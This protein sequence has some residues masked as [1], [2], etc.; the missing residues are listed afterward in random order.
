MLF[1]I[2]NLSFKPT[3]NSIWVIVI[4]Y[5]LYSSSEGVINNDDSICIGMTG[6]SLSLHHLM[7][8]RSVRLQCNPLHQFSSPSSFF[9]ALLSQQESFN[10]SFW[11]HLFPF[12]TIFPRG[13]QKNAPQIQHERRCAFVRYPCKIKDSHLHLNH[14]RSFHTLVPFLKF[15]HK[16]FT[17]FSSKTYLKSILCAF[18]LYFRHKLLNQS[19]QGGRI[20]DDEAIVVYLVSA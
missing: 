9:L 18:L 8:H 12:L 1:N 20:T 4:T 3:L 17:V 11:S 15:V 5:S 16:S 7:R 10:S 13:L 14:S 19:S 6:Q 2:L